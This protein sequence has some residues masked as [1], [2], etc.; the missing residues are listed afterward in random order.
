MRHARPSLHRYTTASLPLLA[1]GLLVAACGGVYEGGG[2]TTPVATTVCSS[3]QQ[4]TGGGEGSS[5]MNPGMDCI[6][7]HA[8]GE[9]PNFTAAGT[10]FG[11]AH[12]ADRCVGVSGAVVKVTDAN[13]QVLQA[14]TG[15][16]GN[17]Y[18]RGTLAFPV[19]AQ[20][21]YDGRTRAMVAAQATADCAGCHTRAGLNG[22]PGRIVA[23]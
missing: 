23:P 15:A 19:H 8:R 22:A 4:W 17:F 7:C 14:T 1:A 12:D 5:Q 6:A 11:D 18:L 10:V 3:G 9:G 21:T 2:A 20:V 13:G 16:T